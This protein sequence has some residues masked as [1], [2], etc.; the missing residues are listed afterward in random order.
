MTGVSA[1]ITFPCGLNI[2]IV[3]GILMQS[4]IQD[5]FRI[6]CIHTRL[7]TP[8]CTLSVIRLWRFE[9]KIRINFR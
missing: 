9:Y 7:L 8:E 5:T 6:I 3:T 2:M 1:C 4:G